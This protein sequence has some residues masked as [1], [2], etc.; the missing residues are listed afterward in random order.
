MSRRRWTRSAAVIWVGAIVLLW[1]TW[2]LKVPATSGRLRTAHVMCGEMPEF[3]RLA[4]TLPAG[5]PVLFVSDRESFQE[6]SEALFCAQYAL[7]PL[8][9][10]FRTREEV[11]TDPD[12]ARRLLVDLGS[13]GERDGEE[14][15]LTALQKQAA[16]RGTELRVRRGPPGVWVVG[17]DPS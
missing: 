6:A 11:L 1:L 8:P 7:A 2:L 17:K 4:G 13:D 3:S 14:D 16:A 5:E 15:L 12:P 10:H 9:L